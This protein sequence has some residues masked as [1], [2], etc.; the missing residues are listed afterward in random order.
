MGLFSGSG[1]TDD[2]QKKYEDYRKDYPKDDSARKTAK[3]ITDGKIPPQHI[4]KKSLEV[5]KQEL[6]SHIQNY[7]ETF[8]SAELNVWQNRLNVLNNALQTKD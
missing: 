8:N 2:P 5:K 4:G 1:R 7:Q 6:I 3:D